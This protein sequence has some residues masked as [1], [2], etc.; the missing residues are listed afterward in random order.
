M[1]VTGLLLS[2]GWNYKD[3][4]L[5]AVATEGNGCRLGAVA[6]LELGQD[7]ADVGFNR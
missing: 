1:F 3:L 7:V 2:V 4:I 5:Y 6:D